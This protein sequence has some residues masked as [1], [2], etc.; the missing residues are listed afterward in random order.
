MKTNTFLITFST[1]IFINLFLRLRI[2][3]ISY[4]FIFHFI[5]D[6]N[7]NAKINIAHFKDNRH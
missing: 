1:Y 5:S 4:F 7:N 6:I 2:R 3:P